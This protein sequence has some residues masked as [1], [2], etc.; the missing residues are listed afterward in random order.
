MAKDYYT[1]T[2]ASKVLSVSPDTVLKWV[3]AGKIDSYRTPGGHARIPKSAVAS[4][5]PDGVSAPHPAS[6]TNENVAFQYCWNFH[7]HGGEVEKQCLSCVAYKSRARRCYEMRDI[8]EQ[9]GHLKLHCVIDC[10][11][12]EYYRT[13]SEHGTSAM[14]VSR[15]K[16][17]E[18]LA[19]DAEEDGLTVKFASSEYEC[20]AM[21]DRFRP[22]YV[23]IDCSFGAA[24]TRDICNHLMNDD[25]IPLT[26]I[27]L[28][29]R[30][31]NIKDCCDSE[32]FGWIIKPFTLKQLRELI[33]GTARL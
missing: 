31:A 9:F 18:E 32:I 5:L 13:M 33:E 16:K 26:R 21:V 2:E 15:N 27:I 11:H 10:K 14:I 20:A 7:S 29:S 17:L 28:T 19:T 24:R 23:V 3:R 12:C 8:P 22:D 4:M 25:R 30:S 1:T 6:P